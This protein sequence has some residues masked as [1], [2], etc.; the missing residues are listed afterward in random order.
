MIVDEIIK[1]ECI[2][3]NHEGL[4]VCKVDGFPIFVSDMLIGEIAKVKINKIDKSFARGSIV[5]MIKVSADRIKP[6]CGVYEKCGGCQLMHLSY[7]KQLEFK[8]KM[9]EET[10]KRIG[11]VQVE[12]ENI[13]GMDYPYKYRN[14][15][16]VPFGMHRGKVTCGFYKQKTH[17]IIPLE[18]CY[19][20][21]DLSTEMA[22]FVKN[23]C[24]ELRI[25][26]NDVYNK[27]GC[28]RHVLIRKTKNDEYMLVLITKNEKINHCDELIQK[29]TKRFPQ[30][31]S[32]IQN[33]NK[34]NNNVILGDKSKLLY[35]NEILIEELCGLKF[36]L[37]HQSFFQTNHEQTEKLYNKVIEYLDPTGNETVIDAYC[38]VGT[39]S[40]LIA[41]NVKKVYGIEIIPEAIENAKRN[42]KMNNLD[43]ATFICG[44]SE[45]EIINFTNTTI[46]AVVVDPPR[47]GLDRSMVESL[48]Q[49]EVEKIVYVS[50]DVATLARD[51]ALLKEKYEVSRVSAV[52][53]F[54]WTV[55]VECV[56]LLNRIEP[57]K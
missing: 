49:K 53:M 4:G 32:I 24:N 50:C 39:I 7:P 15:V 8:K 35:G 34:E 22:R 56:V 13:Y 55:H 43:N 51:I 2:D 5:Q 27:N 20:Q 25:D 40:L 33:I 11:H 16:Q 41:K 36:E 6:I 14:K 30:I 48:L 19:I 1:M 23:V 42:A 47:K 17:D 31:K 10:I 44:A 29:V 9:V 46:D 45:K 37:S 54:P 12:V 57:K 26:A 18:E 28:M 52:D 38:G 3:L 21:P